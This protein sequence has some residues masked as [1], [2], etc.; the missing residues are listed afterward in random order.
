MSIKISGKIIAALPEQGGV[1]KS[2]NNWRK[3][4]YVL[5]TADEKYPKKIAFT[6]M[7]DNIDK[8]GLAVGQSV[9]VEADIDS[10]EFNGRWYTTVQAW[11]ATIVGAAPQAAQSAPSQTPPP[12][13]GGAPKQDD[14]PF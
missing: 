7:N 3:R 2:G 6:V 5:E 9:E 13:A 1:A 4:E 8:F 12:P 11:K 10:R 14:F